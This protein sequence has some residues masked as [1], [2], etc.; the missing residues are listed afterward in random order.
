MK[1]ELNSKM[2]KNLVSIVNKKCFGILVF[3]IVVLWLI[4]FVFSEEIF[5]RQDHLLSH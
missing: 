1:R 2:K 5:V 4:V 3:D